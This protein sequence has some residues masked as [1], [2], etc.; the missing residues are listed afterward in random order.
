MGYR[1][2]ILSVLFLLPLCSASAQP[3]DMDQLEADEQFRWGVEAFHSGFYDKAILSFETALSF[4]ADSALTRTW[5]GRA[6]YQ[7]GRTPQALNEWET[8]ERQGE[9]SALLSSWIN[10]VR[11]RRSLAPELAEPERYV[12]AQ[13]IA[14]SESM[15]F[16]RPT[17]VETRGDGSFLLASWATNQ[18]IHYDAN[19]RAQNVLGGGL[20]GFNHPYDVLAA[21]DALFISEFHGNRIAK[22]DLSGEKTLTF[23]EKGSGRGDLL[24]PQYLALDDRG[25][26][27]VT[28]IGNRRLSKFDLEGNF[29]LSVDSGTENFGGFSMPT[30]VAVR[31]D[32]VFVA[33][34]W[35]KR[36]YTFDASGNFLKVLG[37]GQLEAPEGISFRDSSHL[38]VADGGRIVELD[39]ENETAR[40][41]A[42]HAGG[43]VDVAFDAN[44]NLLSVDHDGDLV[45]IHA[46]VSS[47]YTGFFPQIR[48]I[49]SENFPE[50]TVDVS[51]TTRDGRP[52]VGMDL[53]NF[54]LSEF[55]RPVQDAEIIGRTPVQSATDAVV[56]LERSPETLRRISD[57]AKAVDDL[58]LSADVQ[59]RFKLVSCAEDAVT[60]TAFGATRL[61]VAEI[62]KKGVHTGAWR[63]DQGVLKSV[64]ELMPSRARRVVLFLSSGALGQAAYGEYSVMEL[65]DYLRSNSV[66]F[67]TIYVEP[68]R[69]NP[70]LEYLSE[71]TGGSSHFIYQPGGVKT[72]TDEIRELVSPLYFLKYV[73]PSDSN[74]G[75]RYIDLQMT[76]SFQSRTGKDASGYYAPLV[77]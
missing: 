13:Q 22:C 1:T 51:V 15:P 24:G 21:E 6:F 46:E 11:Y 70:D 44:G 20:E 26:L 12:V 14:A 77:F 62:V 7:S 32:Q 45:L 52:V 25:Y 68:G 72:V 63:F 40:V 69:R 74:F 50:V 17:A 71:Q 10:L 37:E 2:C 16:H 18:I 55:G 49:D 60:E 5:L 47:L 61:Q 48:R 41:I 4:K 53:R 34:R 42:R 43:L 58:Y 56:L 29:I 28:D 64:S 35:L 76:T 36:V 67:F 9:A 75:R 8:I 31:G 39:I 30:G 3:I 38:I 27:Y 19:G 59:M 73:S 33:D 54:Q 57:V 66:V 65:A 23:G